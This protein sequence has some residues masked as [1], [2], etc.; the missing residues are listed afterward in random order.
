MSYLST[1]PSNKLTY[2]I[3]D[4]TVDFLLADGGKAILKNSI[5]LCGKLYCYTAGNP[6][7]PTPLTIADDVKYDHEIGVNSF[8]DQYITSFSDQ[9]IENIQEV[10]RWVKMN[11]E[12][13]T[14]F[15]EIWSSSSNTSE[16]CCDNS[17]QATNILCGDASTN[18]IPFCF[19]PDICLNNSTSDFPFSKTGQIKLT[20]KLNSAMRALYGSDKTGATSY[21][22][23][24]LYL[25]YQVRNE[26]PADKAQPI[27]MMVK[28]FVSQQLESTQSSII[29]Q[30]TIPTISLSMSFLYTLN[31]SN[32][33]LN[34]YSTDKVPNVQR[35]E[36]SISDN[37]SSIVN[38]PYVY[39]QE[40][41]KMY[42]SSLG[43]NGKAM[44]GFKKDLTNYGIGMLYGSI[45]ANTK[46]G[47]N[48]LSDISTQNPMTAFIYFKGVVTV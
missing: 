18:S 19:K 5:M 42:L 7:A 6:S 30:T 32:M 10:G 20:L 26:L 40:I 1:P 45:S 15:Q 9:T 23:T 8:V 34:Y 33:L 11:K 39:P 14:G 17:E 16:L 37:T 31:S 12:A 27:Q 4:S 46:L 43:S 41:Q 28:N 3:P 48:L 21:Y 25:W 47:V 24:D 2:Y 44:M 36:F 35:V 38:Y 22:M 13:N 29:V